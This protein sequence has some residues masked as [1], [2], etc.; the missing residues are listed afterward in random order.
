MGAV[1]ARASRVADAPCK[2]PLSDASDSFSVT[3]TV[4]QLSVAVLA[5]AAIMPYSYCQES[6]ASSLLS[7]EILSQIGREFGSVCESEMH[8]RSL[9]DL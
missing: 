3:M 2:R 7:G 5:I 9:I 4:A 1:R 6:F 8:Y